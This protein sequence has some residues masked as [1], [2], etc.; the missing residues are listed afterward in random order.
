MLRHLLAAALAA[1]PALAISAATTLRTTQTQYCVPPTDIFV[2]SFSA[3]YHKSNQSIVFYISLD[4]TQSNADVSARALVSAYGME[5]VNQEIDLCQVL[6]GVLCPL[7]S[8]N[9]SS[10]CLP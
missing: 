2:D 10:E 4:T 3:T 5:L 7:P 6:S 9:I 1:A 8:L